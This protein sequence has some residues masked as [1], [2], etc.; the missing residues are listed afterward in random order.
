LLPRPGIELRSGGRV[1]PGRF[2]QSGIEIGPD[3]GSALSV[4]AARGGG[5]DG[6]ALGAVGIDCDAD[7]ACDGMGCACNGAD[8][9]W[10]GMDCACNGTTT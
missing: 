8:C 3:C 4:G 9:A 10:N 7:C 2:A 1:R 6:G 5:G